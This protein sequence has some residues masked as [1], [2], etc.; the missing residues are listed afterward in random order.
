MKS[1]K[2]KSSTLLTSCRVCGS[3]E[4]NE[5]LNFGEL[6]F[7][8]I[9]PANKTEVVESGVVNLVYC[10]TCTQVQLGYV[11]DADVMYGENYGYM[12]QLNDSM[13]L[14]LS[15]MAKYVLKSTSLTPGQ[16][17]LDVG[18]NDGTFLNFFTPSKIKTIGVDPT[19]T[20]F[21]GN[22]NPDTLQI[23]RLFDA[24]VIDELGYDSIDVISSIAMFY[25]LDDPVDFIKNI[26]SLLKKD[27][28]WFL[29]LTYGA[30]MNS[31]LS[32]DTI[33]HEH[34]VYYTFSQLEMMLKSNGFAVKDV[35][36]TKSNGGSLAILAQKS[37]QPNSLTGYASYL[38]NL[39]KINEIN[40]LDAWLRFGVNVNS[41][42]ELLK[43]FF[44][45]LTKISPLWGLGASTKGNILLELLGLNQSKIVSIGEINVDKF[46]KF[47]P[48]TQIPIVPEDEILKNSDKSILVLPWHFKDNIVAKQR[49]FLENGGN[50][51]FPL[52]D[53]EIITRFKI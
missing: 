49:L 29:E 50:L 51:I 28:Y 35:F 14:H 36:T 24:S 33:C 7:S 13:Q 37:T 16:I 27:G 23:P 3:T 45:K 11:F 22:Y 12:S 47:T 31:S 38:L 30:W 20:K 41:R 25:D 15:N 26:H 34:A 1:K 40:S 32:F 8:G 5:F 53:L 48:G 52:P 6:S 10:K 43:E 19:I 39:E 17:I 4:L 46:G 2:N 21:F 9:F 18:S 44:D 42:I